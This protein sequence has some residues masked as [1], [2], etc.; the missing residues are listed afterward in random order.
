MSVV[1][2]KSKGKRS[3]WPRA[4]SDFEHFLVFV[5]LYTTQRTYGKPNKNFFSHFF[6]VL[7]ILEILSCTTQTHEWWWENNDEKESLA[8]CSFV[9]SYFQLPFSSPHHN[10]IRCSLHMMDTDSKSSTTDNIFFYFSYYDSL[11]GIII[12]FY[13]YYSPSLSFSL[14][15][16]SLFHFSSWN[17]VV[18]H[19]TPRRNFETRWS[20]EEEK[21]K[22]EKKINLILLFSSHSLVTLHKRRQELHCCS[23]KNDG[24]RRRIIS[25]ETMERE[26]ETKKENILWNHRIVT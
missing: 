1:P 10:I 6:F 13:D 3:L 18:F 25:Y 16:L 19:Y 2:F 23:E 22:E 8:R 20:R 12:G 26:R 14:L 4:S 24:S 15:L 11:F 7:L 5:S 17:F 9:V 21:E